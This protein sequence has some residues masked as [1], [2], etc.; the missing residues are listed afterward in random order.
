VN[1]PEPPGFAL[2]AF[3]ALALAALRSRKSAF[4][5]AS[6]GLTACEPAFF[7]VVTQPGFQE[8]HTPGSNAVDEMPASLAVERIAGL[9]P[10]LNRV[11]TLRARAF[12]ADG[13]SPDTV[14]ILVPGFLGGADT[15]APLAQQLVQ[16]LGGDVQV[17]VVDRRPNQLEDRRG[18][19]W[20]ADGAIA[21]LPQRMA[22]GLQFY[23]AETSALDIDQDGVVDPLYTLPDATGGLSSYVK[24]AQNDVR[25]AAYWGLDTY[26]RDW[27]ILVDEAR[28]LVGPNGVV[29]FGGHSMGT[30]FAT[31]FAAYDFDPG[32]SIDPGWS[33]VD[34]LLLLEGGG[35]GAGAAT[36]PTLAQY[37]AQVAALAT[38]GGPD[39]YLANFSGIPL[40]DLGPAGEIAGIAGWFRPKEPS[41]VQRTALFSAGIL[42]TLFQHP[43]DNETALGLFIDDDFSPVGAF[44][45]SIGFSDDGPNALQSIGLV[46]YY[47]AGAPAGGPRRT[48]KRHDDP[49]LPSCPPNVANAGV[50]CALLSN[51][52]QQPFAFVWGVE[53]EVTDIRTLARAQFEHA[54]GVEWY[55]LSGRINLDFQYGRDSSVLGD[56]SLLAITQNASVNVPVLGIGG[57]NGLTPIAA[58]FDPYHASIAT[59]PADREVVILEGYAHLDVIQAAENEAVPAIVAWLD[60]LLARKLGP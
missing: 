18:A 32:G 5:L 29:A 57:S 41:L 20:S 30:S 15:F 25:F 28:A 2:A 47:V 7:E 38:P 43:V 49:T 59:P 51:G 16:A 22:E 19:R 21:Q 3:A 52:P 12:G 44:R 54:N 40:Q 39:V 11:T 55:Y 8:P 50:G 17:W 45:A 23:F 33:H 56:E 24:L 37:Q 10:D 4:L 60:D 42:S 26:L 36:K 31:A 34:G 35:L 48:W 1:L 6:L 46:Q 53:R 14:L 9:S 13:E 58:S 27:K